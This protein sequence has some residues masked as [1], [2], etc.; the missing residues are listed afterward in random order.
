MAG[1][2]FATRVR[3]GSLSLSLSLTITLTLT[4]TLSLSLS[5]SLTL[6]LTLTLSLSLTLEAW[7]AL[8]RPVG[9]EVERRVA[10]LLVA[11]C[12]EALRPLPP[13]AELATLATAEATADA[14]AKA[15]A[16]AALERAAA[17]VLLGERHALEACREHWLEVGRK[18]ATST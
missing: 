13:A 15:A 18:L 10:A 16:G 12:E 8:Q 5:L 4:L 9:D 6:P 1:S 2:P 17:R 7:A 14:G 3:P 11:S